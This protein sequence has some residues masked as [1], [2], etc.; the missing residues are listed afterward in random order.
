MG[1]SHCIGYW[2]HWAN[3]LGMTAQSVLVSRFQNNNTEQVYSECYSLRHDEVPSTFWH[4]RLFCRLAIRR[5]RQSRLPRPK[6]W[7]AWTL[8]HEDILFVAAEQRST[9][10]KILF[11]FL[12]TRQFTAPLGGAY[13]HL[14]SL[15][16]KCLCYNFAIMRLC[17]GSSC[18]C[19][20]WFIFWIHILT[21]TL[22]EFIRTWCWI[23]FSIFCSKQSSR[24]LHLV[25][26]VYLSKSDFR[27]GWA[28][29]N[30][31]QYTTMLCPDVEPKTTFIEGICEH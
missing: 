25:S 30:H 8:T 9:L 5:I 19:W 1:A 28:F 3:R 21:F 27:G 12:F 4:R 17:F 16:E 24:L 13:F 6:V 15:R 20:P 22:Q 14:L 11:F 26:Y 7:R 18:V 10:F 23:I 29:A 31:Y 2:P